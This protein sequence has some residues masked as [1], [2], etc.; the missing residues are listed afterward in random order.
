MLKKVESTIHYFGMLS[1]GNKIVVGVSGGPDSCV[2]LHML[3]F[4]RGK[5]GFSLWSAHL[6]HSM[7]KREAEEDEKWVKLFTQKLSVPLISDVIDVPLLAREEVLGLESVARRVR[8]NFL[9]HVA[10]RVGADRIAVGHTA[11]DQAET[12]LMRLIRGSGID[13]LAGIPPVRGRIIRPLIRIFREEIEDYCHRNNLVPRMDASNNNTVFFRNSVRLELIPYLCGHYNPRIVEVME[14]TS[15][16]LQV[17][18]DFLDKLTDKVKGKVV[19][20]KSGREIVVSVCALLQLHLSLQ[21]R[22]IRDVLKTL[23]GNLKGIEYAHVDQILHLKEDK[24]TK[25]TCLPGEVKVWRQYDE[26]V[27]RKG[28][29]SCS[30]FFSYLS[31]PGITT[32][33]ELDMVFKAKILSKPPARFPKNPYQAFF[34]LDKIPGLLYVRPRREGDRFVP[35]GMTGRKKLAD[36]FVDLKVPRFKRNE[37]PLLL[38]NRKILWVVG[39]RIDDGFKLEEGTKKILTIKVSPNG[40]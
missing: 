26:L 34:D 7:R 23:K 17:D 38:S 2:L 22:V 29:E 18:K 25:L 36:F 9:E 8:Y 20:V 16:L 10:N 40:S 6:N 15:D 35:L 19:K 39:Y 31:I 27:F 30:S 13:G 33:P 3:C 4:L 37:I 28:K 32:I 1:R 11:S 14:R 21:R 24:G 5:Y 12:I